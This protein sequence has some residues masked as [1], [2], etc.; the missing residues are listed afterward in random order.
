MVI[1]LIHWWVQVQIAPLEQSP[2][3]AISQTVRD[4]KQLMYVQV[5]VNL[6]LQNGTR[7]DRSL[8]TPRPLRSTAHDDKCVLDSVSSVDLSSN[9]LSDRDLELR[10]Q[11]PRK[12]VAESTI[13]TTVQEITYPDGGRR[14]WSTLL[15]VYVFGGPFSQLILTNCLT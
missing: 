15:G 9:D 14:A 13:H 6:P 7:S 12:L 2:Q 3:L 10:R 4:C 1:R 11:Q 8:S 5:D